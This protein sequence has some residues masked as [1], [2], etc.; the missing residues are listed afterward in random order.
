MT[1][2]SV[3]RASCKRGQWQPGLALLCE[4]LGVKLELIILRYNTQIS[5]CEKGQ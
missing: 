2:Y 4:M 1:R 3:W 5:A